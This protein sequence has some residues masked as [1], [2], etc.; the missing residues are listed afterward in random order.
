MLHLPRH[1]RETA[2]RVDTATNGSAIREFSGAK[3][4]S[5]QFPKFVTEAR[6]FIPTVRYGKAR[7][8]G[9]FTASHRQTFHC[10]PNRHFP[11]PSPRLQKRKHNIPVNPEDIEIETEC[12][13][14]GET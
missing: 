3:I 7:N 13:S 5:I 1:R 9:H 4:N 2:F 6:F 12:E 11:T 14:E 8:H 10:L